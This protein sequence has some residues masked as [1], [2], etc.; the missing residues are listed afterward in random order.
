MEIINIETR[1][2][3]Q[4]RLPK[5]LIDELPNKIMLCTTLQFVDFIDSIKRQLKNKEISLFNSKHGIH[6]GQILGCDT[7]KIEKDIDAFLYIG[8]GMFHPGAL[9]VNQKPVYVYNPFSEKHS[10]LSAKEI[11]QHRIKKKVQL[12]KFHAADRVGIIVSTK[13]GQYALTNALQLKDRIKD[14]K[15]VF[16]FITDNINL[17]ELENFPFIESWVNTACPRIDLLHIDELE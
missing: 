2:T 6:P 10:K 8:D 14:Q 12:S 4:I 9:L 3:G 5:S 16:L 13:P 15:E 1:Y 7:F 11:N 17:N